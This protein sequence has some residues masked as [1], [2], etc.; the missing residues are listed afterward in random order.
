MVDV[1]VDGNMCSQ[2]TEE[3]GRNRHERVY[4]GDMLA[5]IRFAEPIRVA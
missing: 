3:L 5:R 2:A 1:R 4:V